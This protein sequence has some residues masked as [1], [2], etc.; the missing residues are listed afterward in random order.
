MGN[1]PIGIE[2][3]AKLRAKTVQRWLENGNKQSQDRCQYKPNLEDKRQTGI[4]SNEYSEQLW[5]PNVHHPMPS[6]D[7]FVELLLTFWQHHNS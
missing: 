2:R 6:K 5:Y 4:E 7:S 1:R 3:M